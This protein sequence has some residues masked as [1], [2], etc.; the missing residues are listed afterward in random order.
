MH[1]II[2]SVYNFIYN[3]VLYFLVGAIKMYLSWNDIERAIE[4]HKKEVQRLQKENII[5][6]AALE[7]LVN[8]CLTD[9]TPPISIGKGKELLGFKT[10]NEMR[11]WWNSY[12]D[13]KNYLDITNR[14]D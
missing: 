9:E 12:D 11:D 14:H 10:M 2:R 7:E 13:K 6:R 3:N 5:N 8:I 1:C 4:P